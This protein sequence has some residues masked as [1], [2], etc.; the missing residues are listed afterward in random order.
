MNL[1]GDVESLGDD[2]CTGWC[3]TRLWGDA[4]CKGC[5]RY[6]NEIT[7]WSELPNVYRK[8]RVL[9]NT[10]DGYPSR[11]IKTQVWE[12]KKLSEM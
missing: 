12:P 8:L 10:Q 6:E 2:P 4:R 3:T 11:H 7:G 1:N 9:D 5:G